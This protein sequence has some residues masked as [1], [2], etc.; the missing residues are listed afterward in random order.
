MVVD[1]PNSKK[2]RKVFLVLFVG[3]GGASQRVPEGLEGEEQE[4]GKVPFE[5]RREREHK[6]VKGG[7]KKGIKDTDWILKKKEV[8]NSQCFSDDARPDP[9]KLLV[10]SPA[11]KGRCPSRFQIHKSQKKGDILIYWHVFHLYLYHL[12]K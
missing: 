5:R 11:R 12:C 9:G 1:Y 10:I 8:S 2:A 6:R 3:G 7:K 4:E